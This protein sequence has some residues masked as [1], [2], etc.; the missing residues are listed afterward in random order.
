M[1]NIV[2]KSQTIKK[3]NEDLIKNIIKNEGP[4]TK[5]EISSITELSLATVNK[6][7]EQLALKNEV[8]VSGLSESTGGRRAQLFEINAN[9]EHIIALYYYRNY[10][11]GVVANLLGEIIYQEKFNIRMD[12]Y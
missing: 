1:K 4:I 6:I 12:T 2:G 8:K 7:V 9:L 3:V 10:C 5:L 11:I